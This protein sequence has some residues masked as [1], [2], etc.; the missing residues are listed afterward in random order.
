MLL[1]IVVAIN[2]AEADALSLAST[3]PSSAAWGWWHPGKKYI[4]KN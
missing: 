4:L 1:H 3:F 2:E